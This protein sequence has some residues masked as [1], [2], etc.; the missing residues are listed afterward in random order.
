[1]RVTKTPDP[2][3]VRVFTMKHSR[4]F[5]SI[6]IVGMTVLFLFFTGC[7][8]RL[9]KSRWLDREISIDGQD[10][11]WGNFIQ[12]YNENHNIELCLFNDENFL[13]LKLSSPDRMVQQQLLT[14]GFTVWFDSKG[15]KIKTVGIRFPKG[16]HSGI[17][18][19]VKFVGKK[20]EP[21]SNEAAK[22][23]ALKGELDILGPNGKD[24]QTFSVSDAEK[25]GIKADYGTH[26]GI[27]IYELHIPL[28]KNDVNNY[29]VGAD[30]TSLIGIGFE[31]GTPDEKQL[32]KQKSQDDR[33][34]GGMYGST[35]R[36]NRSRAGR[37]DVMGGPQRRLAPLDVW[38]KVMLAPKP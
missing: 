22:E 30:T 26:G 32:K 27:L 36:R 25:L 38:V 18:S 3:I 35:I 31:T 19:E 15:G 33:F 1:M 14:L 29:A 20:D 9:I 4:I 24:S 17:D 13:N 8:N 21:D 28:R 11:E 12:Y 5:L 16:S 10:S 37:G 6:V 2:G 7:D 34:D 23:K